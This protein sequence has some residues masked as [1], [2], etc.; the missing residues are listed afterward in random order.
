MIKKSALIR[1]VN[2]TLPEWKRLNLYRESQHTE[3]QLKYHI[4]TAEDSMKLLHPL[5]KKIIHKQAAMYTV[6]ST[7]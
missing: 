5:K 7:I 1:E 2:A 3:P 6:K 4:E